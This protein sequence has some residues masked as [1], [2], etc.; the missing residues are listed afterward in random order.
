[1][2]DAWLARFAAALRV[3]GRRSVLKNVP[4]LRPLVKTPGYTIY[5]T[6]NLAEGAKSCYNST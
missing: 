3:H 6:P 4:W 5:A 1:M 2:I